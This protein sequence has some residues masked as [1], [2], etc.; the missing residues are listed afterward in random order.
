[1]IKQQMKNKNENKNWVHCCSV[2]KV[3]LVNVILI[4]IGYFESSDA[5]IY[6][7]KMGVVL[8]ELYE[9][10]KCLKKVELSINID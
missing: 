8:S 7:L 3:M 10:K 5:C 2:G 6:T 4:Q 1:M 9:T